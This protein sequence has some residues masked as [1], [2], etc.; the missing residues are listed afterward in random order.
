[1]KLTYERRL[2]LAQ[3]YRKIL[4]TYEASPYYDWTPTLVCIYDPTLPRQGVFFTDQ[5]SI[6]I[7]FFYITNTREAIGV[8]LHEFCHWH[9]H[10]TWIA[11]YERMYGYAHSPYEQAADDFAREA[12][13]FFAA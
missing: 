13:P 12:L 7:N 6:I 10:P 2:E 8:L 4:R 9:Q 1:M 11:R 3:V 5:K